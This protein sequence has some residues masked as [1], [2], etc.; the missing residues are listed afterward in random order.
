MSEPR[1]SVDLSA[2]EWRLV[3][4]LRAIPASA[5]KEKALQLFAAVVEFAREPRCPEMQADGVP[6]DTP[7]AHCDQCLHVDGMLD[8]LRRRTVEALEP[9]SLAR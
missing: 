7:S 3:S 1:V 2:S 8:A 9:P 6:C 5:L 4:D